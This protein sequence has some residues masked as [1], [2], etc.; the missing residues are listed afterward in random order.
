M[1]WTVPIRE[2]PGGS[3]CKERQG[4]LGPKWQP[5]NKVATNTKHAHFTVCLLPV[6]EFLHNFCYPSAFIGDGAGLKWQRKMAIV[7]AHCEIMLGNYTNIN[8][9]LVLPA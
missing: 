4:T 1:L 2:G 8:Y 9:A 7:Y 3:Q 5:C 6:P